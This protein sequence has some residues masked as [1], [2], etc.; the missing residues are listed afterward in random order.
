M[1]HFPK[2]SASREK[3]GACVNSRHTRSQIEDNHQRATGRAG[4]PRP[5]TTS[6]IRIEQ[7]EVFCSCRTARK[8]APQ[9][10]A[11]IKIQMR[12]NKIKI[13]FN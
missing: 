9:R 10:G 2:I 6:A 8:T 1:T 13:L 3:K 7:E 11:D 5:R 4:V 12:L